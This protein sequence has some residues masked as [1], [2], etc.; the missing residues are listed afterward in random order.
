[1]CRTLTYTVGKNYVFAFGG[2]TLFA[3]DPLTG[4]LLWRHAVSTDPVIRKNVIPME[5]AHLIEG[6]DGLFLIYGNLLQTILVRLD[7]TSKSV[8]FLR[9]DLREQ[10][11]PVVVDGAI[12]CFTQRR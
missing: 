3:L 4:R 7:L 10:P 11:L 8:T 2:G 6:S 12:Y 9:S 5:N 1:M